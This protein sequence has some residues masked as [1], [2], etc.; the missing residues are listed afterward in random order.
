M[1][2]NFEPEQYYPTTYDPSTGKLNAMSKQFDFQYLP[3]VTCPVL[4]R[5]KSTNYT[6]WPKCHGHQWYKPVFDPAGNIID[7]EPQG[8]YMQ[9]MPNQRRPLR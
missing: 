6:M 4:R 5:I 2:R 3:N 7:A 8:I 1:E 9:L